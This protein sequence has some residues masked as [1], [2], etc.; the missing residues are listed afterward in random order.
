VAPLIRASLS[1]GQG[2]YLLAML[3]FGIAFSLLHRVLKPA[4]EYNVAAIAR[5]S[6]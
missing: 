2:Y 3:M 1:D 6:R 4:R 5:R